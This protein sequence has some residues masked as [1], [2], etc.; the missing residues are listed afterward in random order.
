MGGGVAYGFEDG[1]ELPLL[2]A[3]ALSVSA[4]LAKEGVLLVG[5]FD[6]VGVEIAVIANLIFI[7]A[8][9]AISGDRFVQRRR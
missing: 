5:P 9:A 3:S 8:E 1:V 6:I 4:D 7:V 2:G